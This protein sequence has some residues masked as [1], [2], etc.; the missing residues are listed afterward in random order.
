MLAL[1]HTKRAAAS[2]ALIIASA[3]SAHAAEVATTNL[4][5]SALVLDTCVLSAATGVSFASINTAEASN[6]VTPGS[7]AVVC[8]SP[9]SGLTVSLGAGENASSGTRYMADATNNKLPYSLYSD[10]G[11][12]SAVGVDGLIYSGAVSAAVPLVLPVYGQIPQ[13]NY[14]AGLY[15]DTILVTLNY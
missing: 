12:Q 11:R 1:H 5:V 4:N 3:T 6:E 2:A 8:T 13:G 10:S 14:N 9:R 7:V 15:S